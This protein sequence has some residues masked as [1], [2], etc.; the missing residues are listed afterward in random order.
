MMIDSSTKISKK[1]SNQP[2]YDAEAYVVVALW[3]HLK[4]PRQRAQGAR[5]IA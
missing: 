5:P 3:L 4:E 1:S 2:Q